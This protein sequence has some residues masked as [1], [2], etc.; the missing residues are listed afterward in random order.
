MWMAASGRCEYGRSRIGCGTQMQ[1]LVAG[2]GFSKKEK[3]KGK[4]VEV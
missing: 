3:S 2:I 4:T 1:T